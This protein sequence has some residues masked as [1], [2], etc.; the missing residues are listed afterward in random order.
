MRERRERKGEREEDWV[1]RGGRVLLDY[2]CVTPVCP[3]LIAGEGEGGKE[4]GER[5]GLGWER[6]GGKK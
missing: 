1:G 3:F 4:G 5:G 6:G 2:G